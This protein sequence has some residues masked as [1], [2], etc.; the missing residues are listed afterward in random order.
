MRTWLIAAG[1]GGA[2]LLAGQAVGADNEAGVPLSPAEAAGGWTLSVASQPVCT[3]VLGAR[4]TVRAPASCGS[5]LPGQPTGWAPTSDGMRLVGPGGQT[6]VAFDRW[7]N[8]LFVSRISGGR[9]LQLRRG[10]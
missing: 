3:L 2:M 1:L 8:S 5:A 6:I 4:H 9:D 7:S 10:G